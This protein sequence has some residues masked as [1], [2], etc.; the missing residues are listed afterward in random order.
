M[1]SKTR[2]DKKE[3]DVNDRKCNC[4]HCGQPIPKGTGYCFSDSGNYGYTHIECEKPYRQKN[5]PNETPTAHG[6]SWSV[7]VSSYSNITTNAKLDGWKIISK[8]V[9][10]LDTCNRCKFN[11]IDFFIKKITVLIKNHN[12]S[13]QKELVYNDL[14]FSEFRELLNAESLK[15]GLYKK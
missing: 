2:K 3:G 6:F 8:R 11:N 5:E 7:I 15:L 1:A 14:E 9:M 13:Q 10:S 4:L 12:T